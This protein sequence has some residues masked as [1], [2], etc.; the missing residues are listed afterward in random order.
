MGRVFASVGTSQLLQA[1]QLGSALGAAVPASAFL[2]AK[3]SFAV[4]TGPQCSSTLEP[5]PGVTVD[6]ALTAAALAE[7]KAVYA[8][9]VATTRFTEP[10]FSKSKAL[11]TRHQE[12]LEVLNEE[13]RLRCLPPAAPVAG[14]ALDSSFTKLP[15]QALSTLELELGAI[16]ADLAAVSTENSTGVPPLPRP[17]LRLQLRPQQTPRSSPS[18]AVTSGKLPFC[19]YW[20]QSRHTPSGAEPL[21][22]CRASRKKP[23]QR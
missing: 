18:T 3:V 8:Y 23:Q 20:I 22:L 4:P 16:Y 5:R 7:Q 11:L 17:R 15:K 21:T 10:Q 2:P 14:F 13:L 6:S 19:G 9:Q 1:E 12:K